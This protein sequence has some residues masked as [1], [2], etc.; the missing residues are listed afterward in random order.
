MTG[1]KTKN[2]DY[3][4][5]TAIKSFACVSSLY[6]GFSLFGL[7]ASLLKTITICVIKKEAYKLYRDE[8][9]NLL[10]CEN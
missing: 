9:A 7:Y 3:F 2:Q 6:Q 5:S 8:L 10:I 1:W 4:C